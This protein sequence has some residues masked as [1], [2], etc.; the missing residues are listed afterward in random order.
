MDP[1]IIASIV[2]LIGIIVGAVLR[3]TLPG[4]RVVM[5]L[6]GKPTRHALMGSWK[7]SW[8]PLP[9]GPAQHHE[10][11]T[12]TRQ[13]GDRI[14]G[15]INWDQKP[16]RKWGFEGRYDG[17]FLQLYYFPA[18]DA[19]NPDFLD[20]GCY[21]FQRKADGLFQGFSTGFGSGY[22]GEPDDE[23]STTYHELRRI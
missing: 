17:Q 1:A 13:R 16:D 9:T 19:I 15:T 7:S 14:W 22:E 18:K 12:V 6:S 2:G 4:F 11:L 10:V 3:E 21:F 20:Y 8:G 5:W 23:V